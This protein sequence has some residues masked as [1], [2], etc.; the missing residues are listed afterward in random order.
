VNDKYMV[1]KR[2]DVNMMSE[3]SQASL[4]RLEVD[5]A[6]VIRRQDAFAP[7]A[8]DA[9]ANLIT[10]AIQVS[11]DFS[12]HIPGVDQEPPSVIRLR[13]IADYFHEQAALA[14]D[15]HRKLPD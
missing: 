14:W 10:A 6:V 12:S 11:Q 2:E 15:T 13:E 8:L 4:T 7:P 5:D 9:Y 3:E 1:L